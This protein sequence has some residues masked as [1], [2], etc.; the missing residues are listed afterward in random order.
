MTQP[1]F[2]PIVEADQVRQAHRVH[3]PRDWRA[4]RP[5]DRRGPTPRRPEF[6][7]PGPDTGYGLLVAERLFA[8][9]VR[10]AAGES[11]HDALAAAAEVGGAR[12]ALFGRAPVGKDIEHALTLFGLLGDAPADLVAWRAPRLRSAAH[13]YR[14]R[15]AL[16]DAVPEATLRLTPE[17]VLARLGQWRTL[18]A[19]GTSGVT[20][21]SGGSVEAG[22]GSEAGGGTAEAAGSAEE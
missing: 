3:A 19:G 21:G 1:S 6:G 8:D 10:C 11:V 9:R 15:R 12:A 7:T 5:A 13:E 20:T 14:V 17:Q 22:D 2:V 4:T 18:L 16:V